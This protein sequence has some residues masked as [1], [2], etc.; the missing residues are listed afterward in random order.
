[1]RK[2]ELTIPTIIGILAVVGGLVAGVVLLNKPLRSLV[3]ASPEETPKDVEI[4]NISDTSFVV[5]WV[6]V[7]STSGYVQYGEREKPELVISDDRDQERGEI[8]NYFTHL[9]SIKALKPETKYS[10]R[11]GSGRSLYDNAGSLYQTTTAAVAGRAPAA[12]VAYGQ[13]VTA[14][15]D[16]VEGAIVYLTLPGAVVQAALTKPSGSWVI[17][18]AVARSAD[19]T[20]FA[21]Y[22]PEKDRVEITVQAGTLGTASVNTTTGAT[23]PVADITLGANRDEAV[24]AP[25]AGSKFSALETGE[26][27]IILTPKFGERVNTQKPEIMGKAPAGTEITI[28][29]ESAKVFSKTLTVDENGEW[30]YSVP[31]NLEP[32][33]HTVT[34]TSIVDGI[35]KTVKK[36]FVVEAAGVSNAPARVATPSASLRPTPRPTIVPRVA[37]PSTESGT[38]EPGNL[39]PTLILLILGAG[40][41]VAGYTGYNY[42]F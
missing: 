25:A 30:T 38:P 9:V 29:I 35:A 21:A 1:V 28:K 6:T 26:E 33:E 16:P 42:K 40:L 5:S 19:L 8:G 32:G 23:K 24:P 31:E 11:I 34:V 3:G 18:L 37:Y 17:P 39:T 36:S 10:F 14:S 13:V 22:D 20:S 7:K 4:T 27:L 15:E 12:D 41:I 2:K